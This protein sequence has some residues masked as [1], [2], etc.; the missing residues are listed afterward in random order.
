MDQSTRH[1]IFLNPQMSMKLSSKEEW[2]DK[3]ALIHEKKK[4][5]LN[6]QEKKKN[7]S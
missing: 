2:E 3:L 1:S 5:V 4:K 6:S 7:H